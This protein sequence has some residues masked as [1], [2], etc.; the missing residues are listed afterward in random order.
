MEVPGGKRPCLRA[1][2]FAFLLGLA[3]LAFG[4]GRAAAA[5]GDGAPSEAVFLAQLVVLMAAG[6][7]LGEAMLRVGQ[8]SVMGQ[9]LAGILL[10][11]SVLGWL[12]PDLQHLLFPA[13]KVQK[14]MLDAVAQFGILLLLLLTGMGTDLKLVQKVGRA[15]I[16]VSLVGVAL[17]FACGVTLGELLPETLLPDPG[18]RL[19]T[20]LFLGTALSI[21]SIK[22]VAA[23]VSE[24]NFARRNLGQIIVASAIMEDTIGWII[25]AITLG[26]AQ[27]GTIDLSHVARSVL[28]TAL[29]LGASFTVGRRLVYW[30]IR[31]AN[32]HFESDFPVI[33]MILVI[34]GV[35]ALAT[36]AIGVHTVLGAFVAGVLIGE[37]PIL[38]RHIE[39]QLRGLIFAFFMP[40]F[41]GVA[42]LSADL[43][44]LKDPS[45]Q[46]MT[47]ALIAIASIGKFAGAFVG[48]KIG[49]LKRAESLALA[50]AMN[51]R[52]STEVIVA[53]I[54]LSMGALSQSLFTM[55]VAMAV[56]TTT[57]MPP[58]LRWA[59]RRVPLTKAEKERLL[60]E[61]KEAKGFVPNL[62]RLL[63]AADDSPN[64]KFASRLA[65]LLAGPRGLP[66][67]VLPMSTNG[68]KKP[69]GDRA[70]DED[71]ANR[72]V[73]EKTAKVAAEDKKARPQEDAPTFIDV[74]VRKGAGK[75]N[76]CSGEAVAK[77]AKKGYDLL[78]V[79]VE[80]SRSQSG[81]FHDD[82]NRVAAAFDRPLAIVVAN[83]VHL[84]DPI[85]SRLRILVPLNGTDVS[86]R[87]AEVAIAIG[88]I[89]DA[90]ITALYVSNLKSGPRKRGVLRTRG[91]KQAMAI[92]KD[93]V[94]LAD[95]HRKDI[96]TR[97]R[98][99]VAPDQAVL[100]EAARHNL[101]IMGVSRRPGDELF[102]GET[103]AGIF[104]NSPASVVF[105]AS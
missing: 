39:E 34:M 102:F 46:L 76:I 57:A 1:W 35:M 55:I 54:G 80:N 28:G 105:L 14:S 36:Q 99:D 89:S 72:E 73:V 56:V 69:R 65:G 5:D 92:L 12:W 6:R 79:G 51:A 100:A 96:R 11:P 20:S 97:V 60:R 9:L 42:G 21:S 38:S 58:M 37:S 81:S 29:F 33:T 68:G 2:A 47:L 82:V 50:S 91:H 74:T 3:A 61:E 71:T 19:L 25:I 66:I 101:I 26:L 104:E 77:E 41:F 67:T 13:A 10:G 40:V 93:A 4:A 24:M 45:L 70:P 63:V 75:S 86:R 8:S 30:L 85:T 94:D 16:S 53:T 59:L 103:A 22:I 90:P 95:R 23:V 18:K 52:G 48:G 78:L 87:A 31:W 27:A 88:R 84:K 44:V 98:S 83:G 64:G 17:P 49:G 15:A 43:T 32:D 62:E 7:L